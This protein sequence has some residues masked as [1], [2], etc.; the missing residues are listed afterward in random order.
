MTEQSQFADAE[1][2][3]RTS[4]EIYQALGY[5]ERVT[6]HAFALN[7]LAST[8]F[9]QRKWE[10]A[11]QVY[12]RIDAATAQWEPSRAARLRLGYSRI[13][14]SYATRRVDSGIEAAKQL[15]DRETKR[16]G[17]KHFDSA[18]AYAILGA[19]LTFARRD[20]EALAAYRKAMPI[21]LAASREDADDDA[22]ARAAAETRMQVVVELY[23]TLLSRNR[24]AVTD[25]GAETFRLAEAIRGRS[26]E[27]ALSAS[28]ARALAREPALA[29]LARKEQDLEKEIGNAFDAAQRDALAAAGRAQREGGRRAAQRDR[30][31]ARATCQRQA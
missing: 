16:A 13:F 27:K 21:L 2:L 6:A 19:G 22:Q 30:Q 5:P 3:A 11:A 25:V 4:V 14:T 15:I 28:S 18:M 12:D 7:Q 31:A 24:T 29:D 17:D 10:E 23:L 20:D 1:Q 26:V 8:L 9:A